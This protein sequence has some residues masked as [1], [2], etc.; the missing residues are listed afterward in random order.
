MWAVLKQGNWT[1]T[2]LRAGG[3]EMH[4]SQDGVGDIAYSSLN[5]KT[6]KLNVFVI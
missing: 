1:F 4:V 6:G 3:R 2:P 5:E